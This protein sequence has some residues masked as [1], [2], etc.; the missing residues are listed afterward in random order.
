MSKL[1]T[2]IKS[3]AYASVGVNL[4]VTEAIVKRKVPTPDFLTEH[5]TL[6]REEAT[7]T[8]SG[9]RAFTEPRTHK[10]TER[11]SERTAEKINGG[12]N[13]AWDFIGI[14]NPDTNTDSETSSET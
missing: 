10:L 8:L 14:N 9:V 12:C 1:L 5:A 4:L 13:R 2:H 6:A 3:A 7:K 11:L